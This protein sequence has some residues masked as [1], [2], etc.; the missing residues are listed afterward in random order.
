[1]SEKKEEEKI[2]ASD[3]AVKLVSEELANKKEEKEKVDE[4]TEETSFSPEPKKQTPLE[5]LK[6]CKSLIESKVDRLIS[7]MYKKD[8][9]DIKA[10]LKGGIYGIAAGMTLAFFLNYLI[11]IG[12]SIVGAAVG[13]G[14]TALNVKKTEGLSDE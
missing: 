5:K 4:T 11:V 12:F 7:L 8:D 9:S 6:E 3:K 1:M 2:K 13:Y 10:V 14:I